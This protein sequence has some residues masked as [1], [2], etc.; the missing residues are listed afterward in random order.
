MNYH[1]QGTVAKPVLI[2]GIGLHSGQD[3]SMTIFPGEADQG[4][5]F[6]RVDLEGNPTVAADPFNVSETARSTTISD[7]EAKVQTVEHLMA[8]FAFLGVDNA[9]IEINNSEVP[10]LDGS[11]LPFIE[12]IEEVGMKQLG[13]ER[14]FYQLEETVEY[15]D[16]ENDIH[17]IATPAK[18]FSVFCMID[19]DSKILGKQYAELGSIEEFKAE[20]ASSR[21]FCFFNELEY[22][23]KNDLIKGGSL[24]NALVVV[25]DPVTD[26]DLDE[27][28]TLLNTP[29]IEVKKGFL[30]NT[31]PAEKNEPARHK[32]LD[33][34]GDLNLI[35]APIGMRVIAKRPGHH[36][37][38]EL[39]KKIKKQLIKQEKDKMI[40]KYDPCKPAIMG[41]EQIK[42]LL[43]H[44]YPFLLVDKVIS[45]DDQEIIGLKNLTSNEEFFQGHFP[46]NP[47]MPGVLQIEA[48][49]QCGGILALSQQE[50]PYGWDTYFL[51]IDNCKFKNMV[52]P[53]DTLLLKMRFSQPVRRGICVM[54]GQAFVGGKLVSEADLVAKIEKRENN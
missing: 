6:V 48:L 35:N 2:E 30:N 43:P 1:F 38:T 8:A 26:E 42:Q 34:I 53:G 46:G 14:T 36:A 7:G 41:S 52:F 49:A 50:D 54:K 28:S 4:I 27:I 40:P 10:I 21:T 20:I 51:K 15:K 12:R 45:M 17:L 32:L 23:A 9:V 11:S 16:E 44:R 5:Q 33:V 31:R 19:Y 18:D 25:E 24:D 22:L 37:N 39:A 29:K 47:V 3:I 13:K